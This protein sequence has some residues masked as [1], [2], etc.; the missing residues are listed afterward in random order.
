MERRIY[1][2]TAAEFDHNCNINQAWYQLRFP[3]RKRCS[4]GHSVFLLILANSVLQG[5]DRHKL[6]TASI[7]LWLSGTYLCNVVPPAT[8]ESFLFLAWYQ[9]GIAHL[10]CSHSFDAALVPVWYSWISTGSPTSQTSYGHIYKGRYL[11]HRTPK[12]S[13][14]L[15]HLLADN[16]E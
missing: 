2:A 6:A 4:I 3:G 11:E 15:Q 8:S 14:C 7:A 12:D 13:Y 9:G 10:R 1:D 16:R 5:A